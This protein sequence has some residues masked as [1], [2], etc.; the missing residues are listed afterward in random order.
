MLVELFYPKEL[1]ENIVSVERNAN[2]SPLD[3]QNGTSE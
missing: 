3:L 2:T 1:K